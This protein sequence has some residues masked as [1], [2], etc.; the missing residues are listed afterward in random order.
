MEMRLHRR[1]RR[2]QVAIKVNFDDCAYEP[3][4]VEFK[5]KKKRP[6]FILSSS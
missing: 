1:Y 3:R 2:Y 5:K 6:L 4:H